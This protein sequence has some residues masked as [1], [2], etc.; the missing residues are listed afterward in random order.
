MTEYISN[1][2]KT[3]AYQK[4]NNIFSQFKEIAILD[5][6]KKIEQNKES[7]K[8]YLNLILIYKYY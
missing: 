7:L 3:Q 1:R 8:E 5:Y 6:F 2:C 4:T